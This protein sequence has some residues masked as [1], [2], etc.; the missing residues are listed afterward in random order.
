MVGGVYGPIEYSDAIP[1]RGNSARF[2]RGIIALA[3]INTWSFG[4]VGPHNFAAKWYGGRAG[5]EVRG[6]QIH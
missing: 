6:Y 3:D 4:F 1:S 2:L 5:L